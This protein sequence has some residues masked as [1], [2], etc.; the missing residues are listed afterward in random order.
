VV[1]RSEGNG[2]YRTDRSRSEDWPEKKV[3]IRYARSDLG[4]QVYRDPVEVALSRKGVAAILGVVYLLDLSVEVIV[5]IF[6][7]YT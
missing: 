6:V 1:S 2:E 5:R 3:L 7:I 4:Q